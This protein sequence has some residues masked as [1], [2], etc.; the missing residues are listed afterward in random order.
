MEA[1]T[2]GNN[3][4][5]KQG[6]P[7]AKD[8]LHDCFIIPYNKGKMKALRQYCT[9]KGINLEVKGIEFL[10][11]LYAKVVPR[12]VRDYLDESENPTTIEA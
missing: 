1:R 3:K 5:Q 8:N 9:K 2:E 7:S 12:E 10:D 6:R 11:A 4:T